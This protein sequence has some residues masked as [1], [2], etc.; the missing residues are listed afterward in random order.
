MSSA[1]YEP[2]APAAACGLRESFNYQRIQMHIGRC[3]AT[4]AQLL[5]ERRKGELNHGPQDGRNCFAFNRQQRWQLILSFTNSPQ[6]EKLKKKKKKATGKAHKPVYFPFPSLSLL[7]SALLLWK[8]VTKDSKCKQKPSWINH[9]TNFCK[10]PFCL[11]VTSSLLPP[12]HTPSLAWIHLKKDL[13]RTGRVW[14]V[15]CT[16]GDLFWY[17][18]P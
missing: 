14:I 12:P 1:G 15:P 2:Q 17:W 7:I 4:S 10:P 6:C 3:R 5:C 9:N 11:C 8:K 16:I 13:S 18:N